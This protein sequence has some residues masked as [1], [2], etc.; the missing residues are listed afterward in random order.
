MRRMAVYD[1]F[2]RKQSVILFA[3]DIASRGLDFPAV[4]WVLQLDCPEDV[5]TYIHRAGRTARFNKDGQA[6]L[7]L[8]PS[9]KRSM[10]QQLEEKKIPIEELD[11]NPKK[12]HSITRRAEAFLACHLDL[13]ESAQRAFKAYFK[14]VYFMKDK[15]VFDINQLDREEFAR[16]LGLEVTPRIRFLEKSNKSQV[17]V[18]NPA[19]TVKLVTESDHEEDAD[20]LLTVKSI[21]KYENPTS[22]VKPI[23]L[24]EPQPREKKS[25]KPVTKASV[26]KKLMKKNIKPN[27]KTVFAEDGTVEEGIPTRQTSEKVKELEEKNISGIDIELAKEIMKDE[28][29]I[30]KK[31]RRNLINQKHKEKKRKDKEKKNQDK[32]VE[33]AQLYVDEDDGDDGHL[34]RLIDALP[35]PKKY[36]DSDGDEDDFGPTR[37]KQIRL[38]SSSEDEHSEDG[39]ESGGEI[40]GDEFLAL[41]LLK[42]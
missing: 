28:D 22:S 33:S 6:M 25:Q 11:I 8:L 17:N 42:S 20:D 29:L 36:Y 40:G 34:D 26:A 12:L 5:N 16:S 32:N 15:S 30:D 1:E 13:K 38:A 37:G 31:L 14:N 19:K 23:E 35:D 4:D 18:K 27:K 39:G 2:C 24:I 21:W 41:H 7:I 9:E 3:T 10:I